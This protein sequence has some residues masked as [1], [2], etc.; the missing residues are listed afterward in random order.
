M[1]LVAGRDIMLIGLLLPALFWLICH[2][3]LLV[4]QQR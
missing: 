3:L 1:C 2:V 4:H